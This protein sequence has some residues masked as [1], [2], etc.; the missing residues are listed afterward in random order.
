M[1]TFFCVYKNLKQKNINKG[2][3]GLG[4]KQHFFVAVAVYKKGDESWIELCE[5]SHVSPPDGGGDA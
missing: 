2:R 1:K 5:G 4:R 3:Q